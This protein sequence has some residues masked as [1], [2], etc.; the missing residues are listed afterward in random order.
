MGHCNEFQMRSNV[1]FV[2]NNIHGITVCRNFAVTS[3]NR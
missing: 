2:A 3:G 1:D